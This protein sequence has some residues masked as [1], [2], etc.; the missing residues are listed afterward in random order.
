MEHL[1]SGVYGFVH[2]GTNIRTNEIVAIKIENKHKP[3]SGLLKREAQI[4]VFLGSLKGFPS[5]KWFG[6]DDMNYYLVM[7]FLVRNFKMVTLLL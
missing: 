6:S 5:V 2:K 4:Y 3:E 7:V 1:N